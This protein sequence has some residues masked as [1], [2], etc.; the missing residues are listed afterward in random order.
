MVGES[1]GAPRVHREAKVAR[2]EAL[3]LGVEVV[4]YAVRAKCN[5]VSLLTLALEQL[6]VPE[7]S[8]V[9][10]QERPEPSARVSGVG[11]VAPAADIDLEHLLGRL[12]EEEC[13]AVAHIDA[14]E[15]PSPARARALC[16]RLCLQENAAEQRRRSCLSV[17]RCRGSDA[18]VGVR[19]GAEEQLASVA[20][21]SDLGLV[22]RHILD[23]GIAGGPGGVA[24]ARSPVASVCNNSNDSVRVEYAVLVT[25]ADGVSLSLRMVGK[26]RVRRDTPRTDQVCEAVLPCLAVWAIKAHQQA[27]VGMSV[28]GRLRETPVE[29]LG[30]ASEE[31]E[32]LLRYVGG[33]FPQEELLCLVVELLL[34]RRCLLLLRLLFLSEGSSSPLL[35]V[36]SCCPCLRLSSRLALLLPTHAQQRR[37]IKQRVRLRHLLPIYT[38]APWPP[39]HS[40]EL[41][42][43]G[44]GRLLQ[45]GVV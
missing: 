36:S 44:Y 7:V 45:L 42:H 24:R 11:S 34:H 37:Q 13:L 39:L 9:L 23:K 28:H 21:C 35:L 5:D 43:I 6:E 1:C 25:V 32:V 2:R 38:V 31:V 41:L 14:D 19:C 12:A 33:V 18:R 27:V 22:L 26:T 4:E 29:P 40:N 17:L 20:Y 8:A 16:R 3:R 15:I 30:S 10:R